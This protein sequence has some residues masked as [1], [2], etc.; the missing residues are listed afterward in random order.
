MQEWMERIEKLWCEHMHTGVMWPIH[1]RYRCGTCLREYEV[2][3]ELPEEL[4]ARRS[5][6]P[7]SLATA[8]R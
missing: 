4:P 2:P 1:G 6:V 8:A 7:S 5:A 3:F